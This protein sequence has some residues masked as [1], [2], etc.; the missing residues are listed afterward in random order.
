[1]CSGCRRFVSGPGETPC[2]P[3]ACISR[4]PLPVHRV[5]QRPQRND[6][7]AASVKRQLRVLLIDQ[8]HEE[9][10]LRTQRRRPV[11]PTRPG[12]SQE[13][14]L[15]PP[16][17]IVRGQASNSSASLRD[18][19]QRRQHHLRLKFARM[20]LLRPHVWTLRMPTLVEGIMP[21]QFSGSTIPT[22]G[23]NSP[24]ALRARKRR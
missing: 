20:I 24:I 8:I 5:P 12:Q 23:P 2:M 14:A 16:A 7:P 1:M 18:R 4:Y 10:V 3:I 11:I 9:A 21:V 17:G 13:R 15:P 19:P 22:T 6:H